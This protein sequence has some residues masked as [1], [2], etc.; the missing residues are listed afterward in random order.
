MVD[1]ERSPKPQTRP[2]HLILAD[3]H[4]VLR[5]GFRGLLADEPDL[6]IVGEASN[7]RE[8]LELCRALRPDLV[9]MDVRMPEMD[10]LAATR[11]IKGEFPTTIVLMVTTHDSPDYL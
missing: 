1:D 2:V 9:L 6:E 4:H 3:D 7:G 8:A 5:K 11:A 10:G